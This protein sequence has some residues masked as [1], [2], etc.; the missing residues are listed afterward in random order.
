MLKLNQPVEEHRPLSPELTA[1]APTLA[2]LTACLLSLKGK[3]KSKPEERVEAAR[4]LRE[5]GAAA[6]EPLCLALRDKEDSVRVAAAKSLGEV[7]DERAVQPLV[8]ALRD[9]LPGRSAA[10]SRFARVLFWITMPIMIVLGVIAI[11]ADG[12]GDFLSNLNFYSPGTAAKGRSS[13]E[14][15]KALAKIAERTNSLELRKALPELEEIAADN[16]QQDVRSRA[17]SRRAARKIAKLTNSLK[18]LPISAAAP[19]TDSTALPRAATAPAPDASTLPRAV[20]K[21]E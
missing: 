21:N 8:D 6:I 10:R 18:E 2:E 13:R 7:G 17:T 19:H 5:F 3:Q 4:K 16:L 12:P 1:P 15:A 9:V 20:E 11:F 14:I